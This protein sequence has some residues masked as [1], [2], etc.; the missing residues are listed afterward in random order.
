MLDVGDLGDRIGRAFEQ[1]QASRFVAQHALDAR[2]ILDRQQRMRDAE[3]REQMLHEIAR[4]PVR[5]DE[6]EHVIA[7]LAQRQQLAAMVATPDPSSRQSSRPCS[8]ASNSSSCARSGSR[9]RE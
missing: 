2:A 9:M 1:H 7:L 5:L 6:G 4:R 3:L 8:C